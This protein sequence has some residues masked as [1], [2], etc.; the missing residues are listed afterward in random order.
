MKPRIRWLRPSP[1][2][3]RFASSQ[4]GAAGMSI[5]FAAGL[6]GVGGV[7]AGCTDDT[8]NRLVNVEQPPDAG[9]I[10][11]Q[12]PSS[13]EVYFVVDVSGSMGPFLTDLKS[14]LL[15]FAENFAREDSEGQRIRVDYYVV[16]FVNDVK[17]Y[18]GRMTS[19]ISL[20]SALQEAID[21]G[22]TEQNLTQNR[23]NA[24]EA[25]NMLDA[26][27][28]V[29]KTSRDAEAKLVLIAADATFV[30]APAIL[31]D[32]IQ[33]KST[34]TSIKSDLQGIG[35]RV[36]AF[37]PDKLDGL[38]RTYHNEPPLTSLAGS[39]VNSLRALTGVRSKIRETLSF[40]AREAAC[41]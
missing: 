18:G 3:G 40:I 35:A 31:S 14:E 1:R 2:V 25:E 6:L 36:H 24:E 19:V 16:A 11:T 34:Y 21:R 33:V 23:A 17:M 10:R 22:Q 30:E 5:F 37:V 13:Y 39:T 29:V 15:G 7:G 41:N 28:E 20:Q 38:T 12:E 4:F 26:L 9:C 8:G 27:S 32:N